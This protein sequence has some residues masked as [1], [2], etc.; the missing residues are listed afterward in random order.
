MSG[1]AV[2]APEVR[3]GFSFGGMGFRWGILRTGLGPM[4]TE[5]EGTHW[6]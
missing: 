5:G 6:A 1:L 3:V 2:V 4:G